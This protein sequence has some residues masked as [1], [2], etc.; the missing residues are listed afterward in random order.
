MI[1]SIDPGWLWLIGGVV[2]LI[3]E[4]IAPGFF[5]VFIGAAAVATGLFTLL[6]DL[7]AVPQ[8]ALF[9]LYALLAVM[10][11]RRFYANRSLDSID[12]LLNDR[13]ARLVGKVVTVVTA[14]DEHGGRVRVGDGE[15]SARGGPAEAGTRVR[16][17]G[18]EG[19]CLTVEAERALSQS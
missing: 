11:G 1:E 13:A 8:L 15:W 5:L 10:I 14:V 19:N 3:A 9:A 12:P 4:I 18:V 2:L 16:I 17:T 6:F 7:G